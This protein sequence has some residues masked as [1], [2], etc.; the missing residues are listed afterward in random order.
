[1]RRIVLGLLLAGFTAA[2][3]AQLVYRCTAKGK[4]TT[5]QNAPCGAGRKT[6]SATAYTPDPT[7]TANDLAWQ[8]YRTDQEMR[9]RGAAGRASASRAF[10]TNAPSPPRESCADAKAARDAWER[11]VGL[12]R[13]V[14]GLRYW[15]DRV[16]RA[17]Q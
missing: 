7:P 3:P 1:M 10:V 13:T 2:A 5:F 9:R 17:C 12:S 14:D 11:L 16:S 6:A 4:P 8:R 15:T